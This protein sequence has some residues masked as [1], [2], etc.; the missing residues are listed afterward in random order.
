MEKVLLSENINVLCLPAQKFPDT[1]QDTHHQLREMMPMHPQRRFFGLSQSRP[2][3]TIG[4]NAAAEQLDPTEAD[5]LGLHEYTIQ[6]GRYYQ[7]TIHN[8]PE[9]MNEIADAFQE[10]LKQPDIDPSGICVEWYVND[11]DVQCMVR[12]IEKTQS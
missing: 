4:Y 1:I 11:R 10:I 8:F 5:I 6:E 3:G 9:K 2:D 12:R 7:I